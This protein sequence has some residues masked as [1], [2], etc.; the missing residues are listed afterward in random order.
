VWTSRKDF[1][2]MGEDFIVVNDFNLK[3][4]IY[5]AVMQTDNGR[6][7]DRFAVIR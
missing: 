3:T 2:D 4:G 6:L 5:F 1:P 7:V